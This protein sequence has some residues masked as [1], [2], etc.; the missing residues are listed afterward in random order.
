[1]STTLVWFRNDLRLGDNPAL[2]RAAKRGA[3][4]P[5]F[6][7]APDEEEPWAPGGAHRW[8][9]HE[10]LRSLSS[11]LRASG[12][13]LILRHGPTLATLKDLLDQHDIDA[14]YW[15]QRYI[16]AFRQRDAKIEDVLRRDGVDVRT[17]SGRILHDPDAI[18]TGSGNPY[19][20]FT[21]FWTKLKGTLD[22]SEPL[23]VPKKLEQP[24]MWPESAKLDDF[25]LT[26]LEQDGVD[27][28]DQMSKFWTPTEK[29]ALE[30]LDAFVDEA[31][32]DY[33]E[34]RNR[35]DRIGSSQL[36]PYLHHGQLS[37]RQVWQ[38]VNSWVQNGAMREAADKYLSEIGWREFAY[39]VLWHFPDLPEQ[40]LRKKFSAFN[41]TSDADTLTRWQS[42]Q[43]GYPIVDAGMRQLWALG[44][45][46][47]RVR[48]IAGSFLTKHLLIPWQEGERWFWDTLVDGD[49]ASNAMNWQWIAGCGPDAQPF[50]RIFNPITQGEKFDPE[51]SYVREW[52]PE[53]TKLSTQYIH[54]PWEAPVDVLSNANVVLGDT[55]PEPIVNHPDARRRALDAWER[56]K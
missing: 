25:D 27:W 18:K 13:D 12:S 15:T 7:W 22:V 56:V 46:H 19:Q 31:L 55:Y 16:P 29:A 35:P 1:M 43:T 5:V 45:M 20:V 52:V 21:P 30:H 3:V 53:L 24:K 32:I 42:G 26:P 54:K 36:S 34:L 4:L 17:F 28:A 37:P 44:W 10:S 14:V 38:R 23:P 50:F 51:G 48:M 8:W 6:I 11:A 40:P 49:L 41:W 33:S 2:H 47:N 9:L 39:H